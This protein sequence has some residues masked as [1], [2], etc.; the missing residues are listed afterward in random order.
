MAADTRP[1]TLSATTVGVDV[2]GS[3]VRAVAF[4]SSG[5]AGA[6]YREPT[7]TDPAQ[8]PS[9]ILAAVS[10]VLG[11]DRIDPAIVVGVG[12]PGQVD[13]GRGLVRHAV[14]LGIGEVAFPLVARLR[15][16]GLRRVHVE[17]DVNAAALGVSAALG[18]THDSVALLSI[19]TGIAAGIVVDGRIQRGH[20]RLAGEIGHIPID[21][22]GP[23]CA[24]GQRGCLEAVASGTAIATALDGPDRSTSA[25]A[26][27]HANGDR[28]AGAMWDSLVGGLAW[29]TQLLM[30][31]VDVEIVALGGGAASVGQPLLDAVR[32]RL[33]DRAR[34]APV[35]AA[36]DMAA[37]LVLAPTSP[38]P[39]ALGARLAA[40]RW[41]N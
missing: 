12:I 23:R 31:T 2:G 18:G 33:A 39:G 16:L 5:A 6:T 28:V 38:P 29:A 15:D 1:T 10:D 19:G 30:L 40:E 17:N 11:G 37:N 22:R 32:D 13:P 4:D 26:V 41:G 9:R 7:P 3:S 8:L 27:A 35:L 24:C 20:R 34:G 21:P 25:L 36:A 14:N